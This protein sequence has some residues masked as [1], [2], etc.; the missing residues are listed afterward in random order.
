MNQ[1]LIVEDDS[2][3]REALAEIIMLAGHTYLTANNLQETLSL[4][5]LHNPA[6]ILSDTRI[7]K[8]N[9]R[10]LLQEVQKRN[11]GT[12]VIL[13]AQNGSI[14]G[15]ILAVR[16]GAADYLQKPFSAQLLTDKINP[17]I[18]LDL[19]PDNGDPVA[20]D[21]KSQA[22]L[23]M[24]LKVAR[25]DVGVLI[26]GESGTG[27]EVLA[28]YIHDH[29]SRKKQPFI[30]INCA[31]IPEQMLEATLFGYEKG[32]FTGAYKSTP[33]KF[34]LA[35]GG[36]LLLDEVSEMTLGLQAKLLRVLQEKEVER[37]GANKMISLDVRII[38]TTNRLLEEEI[39]AG[40][41][42]E[43]L[44]YRLNVFPLK[45]LPL[46]ERANDILPLANYLIRKH[47]QNK[48]QGIPQISKAA[49]LLILGYSW[50]GNA[51]ELDNV[52]QRA[53]VLQTDG[54]IDAEHL[55]L[56]TINSKPQVEIKPVIIGKKGLQQHEYAF[57][58]QTLKENVGNREMVA[59]LLGVS[60]RTLRYKLA[61]MREEGYLV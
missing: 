53:L 22:L 18:R 19:T 5:E 56:Q 43:D 4:L 52:I 50:P 8:A 32:A 30:A 13:M 35:Q 38:A 33:G 25:F 10:I 28:H 49:E 60:G 57:I 59:N 37:I 15:A 17:F 21:A 45:W 26:S 40:R 31:A 7:D 41:F 12:P 54:I 47:C 6:V 29:S 16:Q 48:P 51:R 14:D 1:V 55:Q 23:S 20:Q 34:E 61:K 46:R 58:E 3:L 27:K 9:G 24:A 11:P 2:I 36:T 44:Y 42:R 39:A